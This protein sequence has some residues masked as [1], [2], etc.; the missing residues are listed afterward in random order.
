M[1]LVRGR[2]WGQEIV[3]V[4]RQQFRLVLEVILGLATFLLFGAALVVTLYVEAN[5]NA[6]NRMDLPL[7][8]NIG[9]GGALIFMVLSSAIFT[10]G[11]LLSAYGAARKL[12]NRSYLLPMPPLPP[13]YEDFM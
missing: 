13:N 3:D 5:P 10:L 1:I 4:R 8:G 9:H 6:G 2:H 12:R 11:G 7:E